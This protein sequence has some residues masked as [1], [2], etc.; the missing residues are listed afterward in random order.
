MVDQAVR[1]RNLMESKNPGKDI[2]F[3]SRLITISSGK[4][5]V[6]KSNFALNLAIN[7]ASH[8]KKIAIIDA[9]F[10]MANIEVLYGNVPSKSLA[11]IL[12]GD[13]T[14]E[15]IITKGPGGISLVSGGSGITELANLNDTQLE[16][17]LET[18]LYLDEKYD[19]ILIDTGAGAGERVTRMICASSETIII[20]TPEPTAI[21]DSY[22][23]IK[24]LKQLDNIPPM[25]IVINR[26]E[27][28]KEGEDIYYKLNRVSHR[29]LGL[30]LK[31]LGYL[32]DDDSLPKAVKKQEPVS[33]AFPKSE[34]S[35]SI[36]AIAKDILSAENPVL[37]EVD[38]KDSFI[39]KFMG[40]FNN[41]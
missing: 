25:F 16:F 35:K 21:T 37:V 38:S 26:V 36:S 29:F 18:F 40:V 5:G 39:K 11:N 8:G 6:G 34:I 31:L 19:I 20:T 14:I 33:I 17:L 15:D 23:L 28:K 24:I 30:D 1:L 13:C 2:R 27:D 4:G 9:D 41:K 32:P 12:N 22:A 7:L 10:G 3:K